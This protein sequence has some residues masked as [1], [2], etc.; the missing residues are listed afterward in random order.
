[1]LRLEHEHTDTDPVCL[2]LTLK[3]VEMADVWEGWYRRL[4]TKA[5]TVGVAPP[6]IVRQ[7]CEV[8]A[9]LLAEGR[10]ILTSSLQKPV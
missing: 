2:H 9:P 3:C 6:P 8:F 10:H 5:D 1:M 4:S 7:L